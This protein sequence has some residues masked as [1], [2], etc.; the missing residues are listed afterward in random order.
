MMKQAKTKKLS[1]FLMTQAEI[2]GIF[3]E[4]LL[5]A[6]KQADE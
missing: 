1:L 2:K 3:Y 5:P 4:D 6:Q